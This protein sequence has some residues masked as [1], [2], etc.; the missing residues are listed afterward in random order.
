MSEQLTQTDLFKVMMDNATNS[1]LVLTS[2]SSSTEVSAGICGDMKGNLYQLP[3][4]ADTVEI[5]LRLTMRKKVFLEI[6]ELLS[7]VIR[8]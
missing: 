7:K 2:I 8:S 6:N 5:E 1:Q 3:L 4:I